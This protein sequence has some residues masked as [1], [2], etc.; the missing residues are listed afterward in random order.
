MIIKTLL[1]ILLTI[2]FSLSA[3]A[4]VQ[5][6]ADYKIEQITPNL[7]LLQGKGGNV[8]LST[9]N[10][11]L[12]IIDD[13]Y[14]DMSDKLKK[15]LDKW[16]GI[17]KLK[18]IVNTH[19]HGD[20]TGG[21]AALGEGV[22]IIAH[23]NVR[24]RLSTRQAIPLFKMVSEPYDEQALPNLTYPETMTLHFNGQVITLEHY[25]NGHTDGDS[26][27]FFKKINVIHMG[28][29]MFDRM[30]PFVDL[31]SGGNVLSYTRNVADIL[32]KIDDETIVIP[33]HGSLANK[34]GLIDYHN[35]LKG[36]TAEVKT[37]K[38]N[39]LSL[40]KAQEKGLSKQWSAWNK[41]FIKEATWISFI[42]LSL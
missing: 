8:V 21:N 3:T 42:F 20:H 41:G 28:D 12:L 6:I 19:W 15:N 25:P 37:M 5:D 29:H 39:G 40:D 22:N 26:V 31:N 38:R 23:D 36:T 4:N 2:T 35:M 14:A 18:F 16:G 7:I 10:D 32:E 33:G 34:Q 11:G 13:D 27:I 1:A 17:E 30:Y 24:Q 9:G